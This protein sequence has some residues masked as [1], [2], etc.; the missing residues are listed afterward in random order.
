VLRTH[1][2]IKEL[3][4]LLGVTTKTIRH[5][6]KMGLLREPERSAAGYRLYTA[7]DV[8]RLR[9]IRRLQSLGLSLQQI[10]GVLGAVDQERTLQGVLLLL[11]QELEAQICVLQERRE[12]IRD[13]LESSEG[14]KGLDEPYRPSPPVQYVLEQLGS[15]LAQISPELWAM[16]MKTNALLDSLQ[17]PEGYR[18]AM[19]EL[20]HYFV[21]HPEHYTLLLQLGERIIAVTALPED[22]PEIERLAEECCK[23]VKECRKYGEILAVLQ[24][25]LASWFDREMPFATTMTDLVRTVLTP[26]QERLLREVSH[27]VKQMQ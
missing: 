14:M 6:H 15:L 4:Q 25:Q 17:W 21:A 18:E 16:E 8:L 26:A 9:S 10:K 3:A 11:D 19:M 7:Q 2:H 20:A 1:L 24:Q 13:F 5:Y 23:L 22:A 27:R 12:R